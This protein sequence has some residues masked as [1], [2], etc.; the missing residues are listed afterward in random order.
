MKVLVTQEYIGAALDEFDGS[1]IEVDVRDD[2]VPLPYDEL[3]TKLVGY[4]GVISMLTDRI[5]AALLDANPQLKVVANCAAGFDNI[6]VEA[7]T[8]RSVAVTNTPGVLNQATADLAFALI[9]ATA[10]RI[11]EGDVF[12]RAGKYEFWRLKQE[13]LGLDVFGQTLG[14]F[15]MGKI[16][17]AVAARARGGFD[18]TVIY[19]NRSRLEKDVERDLGVTYVEF[20]ELLERSDFVSIHSPLTDGTRHRFDASAFEK[21]KRSAILINTG[22]GPI[23]DEAAL[24]RALRDNVIAGAGIDVYEAEPA[25]DPLLVQQYD[26]VVLL[27]HLGSATA[28]TRE[29]MARTAAINARAVLSGQ[30]P[31]N[32]LN[33]P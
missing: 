16:G 1:G 32:P 30:S 17:Q 9:L 22:R 14:I 11:P 26:R 27:P 8:Q 12:S 10:R 5:D 18:M 20:D 33:T 24:A 7:A 28:S 23:V 25:M 15:G 3:V 31:P 13:Q 4:D 21:M 2:A 19:H 6:D 29:K